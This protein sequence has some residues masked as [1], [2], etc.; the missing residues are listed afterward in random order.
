MTY[1][2][3]AGGIAGL[4]CLYITLSRYE[5]AKRM[6]QY[7]VLRGIGMVMLIWGQLYSLT[8]TNGYWPIKLV[9]WYWWGTVLVFCS[10]IRFSSLKKKGE[11]KDIKFT[12]EK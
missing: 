7:A 5:L 8:N 11:G 2:N 10:A 12:T 3:I 6:R 1:L 9:W 4:I